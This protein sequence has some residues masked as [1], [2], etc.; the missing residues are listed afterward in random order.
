MVRCVSVKNLLTKKSMVCNTP[1]NSNIND[2]LHKLFKEQQ[3][4]VLY[5]YTFDN[6]DK[7]VTGHMNKEDDFIIEK[8]DSEILLSVI[9]GMYEMEN[10]KDDK[11]D[12]II[13]KI[14]Q[15]VKKL[16]IN[17]KINREGLKNFLNN[18][19]SD[20]HIQEKVKSARDDYVKKVVTD[21]GVVQEGGILIWAFEEYVMP[22]LP[23]M[24]QTIFSGILEILDII[25]IIGISV[26]GLQVT[27]V[28]L[29]SFI[30]CFLRFDMIGMAASVIAI[31]PF[32]GNF[33]GGAMRTLTKIF[34]YYNK[35]QKFKAR[36]NRIMRRPSP[37]RR[38]IMRQ[39]YS[40]RRPMYSG[41][42]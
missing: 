24:F 7:Y 19:D 34:R 27:G 22:R 5:L 10:N 23:T 21:K 25:L 15:M 20:S 26:P 1:L 9:E 3:P 39:S 32:L 12:G 31:V 4:Y 18:L 35:Y 28:D 41:R 11:V 38:P 36:K 16:G 2:F 29:I 37:R 8:I 6:G 33:I 42:Q 14:E 30:Y 13:D 17:E 40:P